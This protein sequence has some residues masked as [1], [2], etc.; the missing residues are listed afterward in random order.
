MV[1]F[2]LHFFF[3][4]FF[5]FFSNEK[6]ISGFRVS[7]SKILTVPAQIIVYLHRFK[8]LGL[9]WSSSLKSQKQ[10][11]QCIK[12][13]LADHSVVDLMTCLH[14]KQICP[15]SSFLKRI[16]ANLIDPS[17]IDASGCEQAIETSLE[18]RGSAWNSCYSILNLDHK[19][20][21]CNQEQ[22]QQLPIPV[23]NSNCRPRPSGSW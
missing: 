11:C 15:L 19:Y 12:C 5:Y 8:L 4:F 20:N 2:F 13:D 1:F 16:D 14:S 22:N 23:S 6:A 17:P 21:D 9:C 10:W 3:N 18:S 7:G